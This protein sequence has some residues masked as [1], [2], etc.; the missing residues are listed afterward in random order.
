MDRYKA[1][2]KEMVWATVKL[3]DCNQQ[4][5]VTIIKNENKKKIEE[6]GSRSVLKSPRMKDE[7]GGYEADL[8]AE[9]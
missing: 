3:A 4:I 6:K 9:E 2:N 1:G 7:N 8:E 5:W